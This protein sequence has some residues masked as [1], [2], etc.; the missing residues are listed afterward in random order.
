MQLLVLLAIM[1]VAS[2]INPSTRNKRT[3]FEPDNR[4]PVEIP[5]DEDRMDDGWARRD[6]GKLVRT[7]TAGK[8]E[9]SR[10]RGPEAVSGK[11]F[12]LKI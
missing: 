9:E 11:A 8:K 12:Y 4:V 10:S 1:A 6:F 5:N 7:E 3:P 2:G